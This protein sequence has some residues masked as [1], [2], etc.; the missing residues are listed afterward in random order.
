MLNPSIWVGLAAKKTVCILYIAEIM[1][2]IGLDLSMLSMSE[3]DSILQHLGDVVTSTPAKDNR[4]NSN[5]A[6]T[7]AAS[8][9]V[10]TGAAAAAARPKLNYVCNACPFQAKYASQLKRHQLVHTRSNYPCADCT[11]VYLR[12]E[13]LK[14]H[15]TTVHEGHTFICDKCG[16]QFLSKT[17]LQGHIKVQHNKEHRHTCITCG[18]HFEVKQDFLSHVSKHY[19]MN[20]YSCKK[21]STKFIHDNLI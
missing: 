9:D 7:T 5:E 2:T 15:I 13:N 14:M 12:P 1:E 17:G 6:N 4:S 8:N 16:A 21:C 3:D 18:Q 20:N 19:N 11:K 10:T